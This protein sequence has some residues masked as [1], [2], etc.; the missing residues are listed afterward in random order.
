MHEKQSGTGS[1][2]VNEQNLKLF[3]D[4]N[5]RAVFL[6]YS[7]SSTLY[8]ASMQLDL[9][10]LC[11]YAIDPL[12]VSAST[13]SEARFLSMFTKCFSQLIVQAHVRVPVTTTVP[14]TSALSVNVAALVNQNQSSLNTSMSFTVSNYT[15]YTGFTVFVSIAFISRLHQFGELCL[16]Q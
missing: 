8:N 12:N 2:Q 7:G 5:D 11:Y 4:G 16:V 10:T 15:G 13:V 14:V 6:S 1:E 3:F 9:G